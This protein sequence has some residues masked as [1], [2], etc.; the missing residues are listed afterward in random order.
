MSTPLPPPNLITRA[1]RLL[2]K[3][4]GDAEAAQARVQ[5]SRKVGSITAATAWDLCQAICV[6]HMRRQG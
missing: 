5:E 3:Y 1:A 2:A 6:L 4:D